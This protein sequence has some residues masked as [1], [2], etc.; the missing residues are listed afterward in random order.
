MLAELTVLRPPQQVRRATMWHMRT[1]SI[2][3]LHIHT[4]ELVRGP[5]ERPLPSPPSGTVWRAFVYESEDGPGITVDLPSEPRHVGAGHSRFARW[6]R[7]S[8]RHCP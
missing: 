5:I 1:A 7:R 2:R 3:G 8:L 4:S 6:F